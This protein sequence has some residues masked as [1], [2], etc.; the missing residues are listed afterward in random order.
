MVPRAW[1]GRWPLPGLG[2]LG[3]VVSTVSLMLGLLL[4]PGFDLHIPQNVH[5][6]PAALV[7]APAPV[8]APGHPGGGV[9]AT[10]T[11]AEAPGAS[12]EGCP[13]I[14]ACLCIAAACMVVLFLSL[15]PRWRR[16]AARWP[17]ILRR[18]VVAILAAVRG[19]IPHGPS[20]H[21]LCISRR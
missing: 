1:R 4:L 17:G 20:L 9:A 19:R 18:R 16:L 21:T 2:F 8:A 14:S 3:T 11:A 5:A 10:S 12:C 15:V 13:S 7:S 6:A